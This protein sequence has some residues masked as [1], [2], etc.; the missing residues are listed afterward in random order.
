MDVDCFCRKRFT[1]IRRKEYFTETCDYNETCGN[2]IFDRYY[3]MVAHPSCFIK[4]VF[5][6]FDY[7][8]LVTLLGDDIDNLTIY[9]RA[10]AIKTII[11]F[12]SEFLINYTDIPDSQLK[13]S[14]LYTFMVI[15]N[16]ISSILNFQGTD[17]ITYYDYD[18]FEENKIILYL[19]PKDEAVNTNTEFTEITLSTN[20]TDMANAISA[21][22]T[23]DSSKFKITCNLALLYTTSAKPT[24]FSTDQEIEKQY[25]LLADNIKTPKITTGLN[26]GNDKFNSNVLGISFASETK[27]QETDNN[28][29]ICEL[30]NIEEESINN[31]FAVATP[32]T[33]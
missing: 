16:T 10:Y 30:K 11:N 5:P 1:N 31:M 15:L 17:Y 12:N 32:S 27:Y 24:S 14:A 8:K 25:K 20:S 21:S 33:A 23:A 4:L 2:V 6:Y 28:K 7:D 29:S 22:T 9:K 13:Y 3:K 18:A 26:I 19:A